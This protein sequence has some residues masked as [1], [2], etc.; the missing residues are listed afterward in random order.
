MNVIRQTDNLLILEQKPNQFTTLVLGI[1][2]GLVP[3]FFAWH[4]ISRWGEFHWFAVMF[5]L[6]ISTCPMFLVI[7]QLTVCTCK[8]DKSLRLLTLRR[9]NLLGQKTFKYSY[10]DIRSVHLKT[11][12]ENDDRFEIRIELAKGSYLALNEWLASDNRHR[13][14]AATSLL[15]DFLN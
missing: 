12:G 7:R 8:V 2:G 3:L 1:T 10:D 14:E 11:V 9:K 13:A 6:T 15:K 5:G 4:F